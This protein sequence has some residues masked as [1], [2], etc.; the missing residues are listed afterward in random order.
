LPPTHPE[1]DSEGPIRVSGLHA[2]VY[3]ERLYYL[4]EVE[5]LRLADEAVY[6]GRAL[7]EQLSSETEEASDGQVTAAGYRRFV[8]TSDKL[9]LTGR[10]DAIHHRGGGW[11][12]YEHKRGRARRDGDG[13][14]VAWPWD[15]VQVL[16]YA[17][18]IEEETGK[19]VPEGRIRYHA[20]NVTV[21][22]PLDEHGR[23]LVM[24][25]II[26]ARRLRLE[27]KLPP[28]NSNENACIHCSLAPACLPEEER[29]LKNPQW[30]PVRLFPATTEGEILHLL[31]PT[32]VSRSGDAIVLK[33]K[34]RENRTYP[35]HNISALIAHGNVQI[36]TQALHL[37][38]YNGVPVHWFT[39]GGRH[40]SSLTTGPVSVQRKIMQYHA[41][42]N[43]AMCLAL[44]KKLVKA[45]VEGQLRFVLRATRGRSG[46]PGLIKTRID[47]IRRLLGRIERAEGIDTL[48]GLEGSAGR[49]YFDV[50]PHLI[51]ADIPDK[52]W[53]DGRSRR[54]PL[55]RFNA[56][57]SFG[58]SLLYSAV[59]QAIT[60]VGLD[61][62][63]GFFHTPR[64]SG[65]PLVLD[66]MELFRVPIW[67]MTVMASINRHQWDDDAS[68][69]IA[70]D[71]VWLSD[72]GK[73]EAIGLFERRMDE[74]WKH[75]VTG[76]SLTWRRTMELE[77]RLLEKEWSSTPGLFAK[78]R[79]R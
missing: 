58:Y 30:E 23:D 15:E 39:A 31:T 24:K 48:R 74:V 47:E 7:H 51:S 73:K 6:S 13:K 21:R 11:V 19:R 1:A 77:V 53:P 16:A 59:L 17:M 69:S 54:P 36:S 72:T 49:A 56:L 5:N 63:L 20:D 79:I 57:L 40:I 32:T 46:R 9:G 22:V 43:P 50:L 37:C 60:G 27:G 3:C 44:G 34:G 28:V 75:P 64:S 18:L 52:L 25:S 68:F 42:C 76:Y 14:A 62:A 41:L 38:A 45:K 66:I 70:R 67:D 4:E 61:P 8:M 55:D 35:V 78:A 33:Q 10:V 71:R 26:R 29:L 2:L 65:Q 12:P